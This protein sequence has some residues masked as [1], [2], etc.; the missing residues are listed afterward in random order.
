MISWQYS[1]CWWTHTHTHTKFG[2]CV[3]PV[4]W[5]W[6]FVLFS[7]LYERTHNHGPLANVCTDFLLTEFSFE[8]G[9]SWMEI[10]HE[11]LTSSEMYLTFCVVH[12]RFVRVLLTSSR[13]RCMRTLMCWRTDVSMTVWPDFQ[14]L[15]GCLR[16]TQRALLTLK[17]SCL[18]E[19]FKKSNGSWMTR[20]RTWWSALSCV[21][22]L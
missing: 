3:I 20:D 18:W 11:P 10:V 2:V 7:L 19:D 12:G 1:L 16:H 4:D 8:D 5:M 21:C 17:S 22:G 6:F 13:G 14:F 9:W 15:A